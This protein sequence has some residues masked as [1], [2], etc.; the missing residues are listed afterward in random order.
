M[1]KF[2]YLAVCAVLTAAVLLSFAGCKKNADSEDKAE[3]KPATVTGEW[4]G[5]VDIT[6]S[7]KSALNVINP[8]MQEYFDIKGIKA[9]VNYTFNEDG[10]YKRTVDKEPLQK[11]FDAILEK[12]P[13][14]NR[15]YL[16][17]IIKGHNLNTTPE[18]YCLDQSKMTFDEIAEDFRSKFD[19]QLKEITRDK[20]GRYQLDGDQLNLYV[21][22]GQNATNKIYTVKLEPETLT[23]VSCTDTTEGPFT[24]KGM[25]PATYKRVK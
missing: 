17:Y 12:V 2:F 5:E 22:A 24:I 14:A 15:K 8:N 21:E 19:T 16:E 10:T 6:E 4:K 11:Q 1:K 3:Q 23:F 13:D 25:L 18:Q 9:T 7:V 20:E